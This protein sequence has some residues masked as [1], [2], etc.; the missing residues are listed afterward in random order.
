MEIFT[1]LD[2]ARAHQWHQVFA[3]DQAPDA[4]D[5]GKFAAGDDVYQT[6]H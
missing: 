6:R 4:A 3:A 1:L 2:H 5:V